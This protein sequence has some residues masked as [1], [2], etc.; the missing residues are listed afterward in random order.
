MKI[1]LVVLSRYPDLFKPFAEQVDRLEPKWDLRDDVDCI[2]VRDGNEINWTDDFYEWSGYQGVEPFVY[3]KNVNLAWRALPESD[4]LLCGD[5]VRFET[6]FIDP[7]RDVAYSD[8]KIGIA[9]VQL[10]GQSPFVC[11]YFKRSVLEDVGLMDERFVGY[12]KDDSDWCVRMEALGYRTQPTETV[13]ATHGGGTSFLRR[14]KEI[15]SSMEELCNVN[16]RLF[17]EKW[18]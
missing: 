14:A 18:R 9:T 3:A 8:P 5:D 4:I 13:K 1:C 7:L 10:Y 2:L 16:N 11:G 15:G 17:E 6:T 12:G